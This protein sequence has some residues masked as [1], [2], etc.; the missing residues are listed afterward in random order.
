VRLLLAENDPVLGAAIKQNLSHR[1]YIVDWATNG[2]EAWIYLENQRVSYALVILSWTLPRLSGL[3]LCQRLRHQDQTLPVLM[4]I[5][6]DCPEAKKA[7][8]D[9]GVDDFLVKP[10]RMVELLARSQALQ[11]RSSQLAS[12]PLQIENLTLHYGTRNVSCQHLNANKQTI[13][14][15]KKEFQLLEY[16]M[17]HPNQVVSRD[18]ILEQLW[19]I[20]VDLTSNVVAAQIRLLRRK[21]ARISCE[22]LIETVPHVGYRLNT[23]LLRQEAK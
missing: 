21:L 8:F 15:T 3:E 12:R 13:P 5:A 17:R 22:S 9:A 4:L 16:F 23:E 1:A 6:N 14:L 19:E 7:G 2:T 11:P 18:Q 10:F 20:H